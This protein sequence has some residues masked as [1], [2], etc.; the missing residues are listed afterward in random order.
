MVPSSRFQK[1]ESSLRI[2]NDISSMRI[3]TTCVAPYSLWVEGDNR[4][5]SYDS[6]NPQ[7]GAITKNL[8]VGVAEYVLWPP[9]RIGKVQDIPPPEPRPQSY[10]A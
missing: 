7:H 1:N 9:T 4:A 10:W 6:R 3:A 5:N 2:D 8:L